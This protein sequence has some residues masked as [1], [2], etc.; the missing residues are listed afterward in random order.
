MSNFYI[1][2]LHL[3]HRNVL[4][5]DNRP[6]KDVD[7]MTEVIVSNWNNAVG[8]GDHVYVLGDMFWKNPQG[9]VKVLNFLNGNI[10]LV[11]G[12]HDFINN[13]TYKKFFVEIVD[14]K[15]V[16]DTANGEKIT[17][18]LSHYYMPFYDSHYHGG[19]LLHGHSHVTK[20]AD[21]E[22]RI[23]KELIQRGFPMKVYNIGCMYDYM[24]YTPRTLEEIINRYEVKD[25]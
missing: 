18:I 10:H 19:I 20:E 21:E 1:S 24:D 25:A 7:E 2:D 13:A 23:T 5:F 8:R 17:V 9:A 3:F 22:R 16:K 14:S 11:K 15:K 6:F 4:Y 12:N